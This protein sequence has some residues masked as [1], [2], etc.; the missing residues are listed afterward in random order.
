M[1]KRK[2]E[3]AGV[4]AELE[5]AL[6]TV[7][8]PRWLRRIALLLVLMGAFGLLSS[9]PVFRMLWG[10]QPIQRALPALYFYLTTM[11]WVLGSGLVLGFL[12]EAARNGETW[13]SAF[14]RGVANLLVLGG[15]LAGALLWSNPASWVFLAVALAARWCARPPRN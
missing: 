11:L 3:P 10:D 13:S 2:Q 15:V 6:A 7:R 5:P 14:A 8:S 9:I 1:A 4:S 12:A